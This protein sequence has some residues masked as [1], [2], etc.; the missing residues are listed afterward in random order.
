[1]GKKGSNPP[2]PKGVVKP[3]PPPSPP[4]RIY[5]G[6]GGIFGQSETKESIRRGEDYE[7]FMKGY[8]YA[9]GWSD[10]KP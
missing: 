6:I 9:M 8:S 5:R 10:E 4:L 3:P 2:P 7:M 1:M